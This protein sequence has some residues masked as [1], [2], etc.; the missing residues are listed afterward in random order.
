M[1][2]YP[3]II[4]C[5]EKFIFV[6]IVTSSCSD[7]FQD[8]EREREKI[9]L[10]LSTP[11]FHLT[12]TVTTINNAIIHCMDLSHK[13]HTHS[14]VIFDI[15]AC[16]VSFIPFP[17]R[18]IEREE[19]REKGEKNVFHNFQHFLFPS[20]SIGVSKCSRIIIAPWMHRFVL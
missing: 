6:P 19:E 20:L 15:C 10:S 5:Q 17:V 12:R 9:S 4:T 8:K 13:L 7:F 11:L 14:L 2:N 16:V 1:F 18:E 3:K